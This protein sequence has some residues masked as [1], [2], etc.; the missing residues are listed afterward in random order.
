MTGT[1][2]DRQLSDFETIG[3]VKVR[4]FSADDAAAMEDM[5]WRQSEKFGI[6]R[7]DPETWEGVRTGGLSTSLR[8]TR[9]FRDT[10]TNEFLGAVDQLMG[11]NRWS[12]PSD[13]G[14]LLRTFPKPGTP[15]DISAR[16]WHWHG[17]PLRSVEKV[18]EL[19][20]FFFVTDVQSEG[21]GTLLC[22]GS[23]PVVFKYHTEMTP[24]QRERKPKA[25]RT[26]FYRYDPWL[27]NLTG[28]ELE[29]QGRSLMSE[30]HTVHGH[31]L[32]VIELTGLRG[33]AY[34]ANSAVLHAT[35]PNCS[36]RTRLMRTVDIRQP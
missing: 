17:D 29:D 4:A 36:N 12:R 22:E 5:V 8:K 10:I 15:W 34:I 6:D 26:G 33:E 21:G 30:A 28:S 7:D 23:H 35:S 3:Y 25:I 24:D 27:R 31:P 9:L 13:W 11:D 2:T 18:R 1:L 14:R 20:A 16:R 19:T 32:R